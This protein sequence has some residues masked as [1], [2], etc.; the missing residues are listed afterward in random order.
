MVAARRPDADDGSLVVDLAELSADDLPRVGGKAANL[1]ELIRAGFDVPPGFCITTQAYRRAVAGTAVEDGSAQD[2]AAARAAVLAAPIPEAVSDAVRAA[3]ADLEPDGGPVAVRSSATAED[4]PGASFAG[5]QDTYLDVAGIDNVLDAVH[6]CWASLWTDRAVAYRSAQ[7]IDG[8]GVALAVVVQRMVDAAAAGVL[9]TAD[10]VTGRRRQAVLDAAPGLGESVVSGSVDPDHFVVDTASGRILD[11][12]PG[13]SSD[14]R[15][16][17]LTDDQVLMLAALGGRV[18]EAFGSPQ[19]IEWALDAEA[20][21]WVTQSRPITTLYPIPHRGRPL[22]GETRVY[23][24]VSLAQGL[25]RPITPMGIATFRIIGSGFLDLIGR[26]PARI[27]DGPAGFAVAGDRIFV[28]ATPV[29]RSAAGRAI[30][31][32]LLDVMEARSSVVLR[33]LLPDPRFSVLPGTRRGFARGF[34]RLAVRIRLPLIAAQAIISPAAA[35]HRVRRLA[36]EVAARDLP[37][38]GDITSRVDAVVAL[39]AGAMPLAPRSL[40]AA[41]VGFAALSL[42]GRLLRG[43]T[44]PGDLQTVLRSVPDNV[45][46]EMD[47]E[48]WR[49]A[50]RARN[51][52][53]SAAALETRTA[54]DLA[55]EYRGGRLPAVLQAAMRD[56]LS[57][58]GHRAVAEIDLGMP[59]WSDDPSHLFGV[60]SG[61]LRLGA[62]AVTPARRFADGEREAEDM[63]RTL[64]RRA[65]RRGRLRA[66]L[67]AA[68]LR[69]ARALIGIREM[70][71]FLMITAMAKA[72]AEMARIGA[73][74]A[75]SNRI[76]HAED[77]FFLDFDEVKRAAA[78]EDLRGVV[79]ERRERYDTELRRRHVPRVLLSDG[80]ELEALASAAPPG[81][82][83]ALRGTPASAGTVTAS[84]R[85]ILDPAGAELQP[86]EILV[87]PSTDPGW[88][89]LFLTAGGLVMEMGG[90]NSHG[91]VVARE[92][93]IPAV[94]GVPGATQTIS[95]G[96]EVTVDGASGLVTVPSRVEAPAG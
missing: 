9:F 19:D 63:V 88:T 14:D 38:A 76:S 52:A 35:R 66:A 61:Y 80:T 70:P 96:M 23:F 45:T 10:P 64:V 1:G 8:S 77:V 53:E 71:K 4:L 22:P 39:L 93:G 43:S 89:P 36:A 48:L 26:P 82:A 24:C 27:V 31:P 25:H 29:V 78:G 79:R 46:T 56:F 57:R 91:A 74:L 42:A 69:R 87:A 83:G 62:D 75:G 3:Y 81:E 15:P 34:L 72:R 44:K 95:T 16:V 30:F 12:R 20:H 5:Q 73:E 21:A 55:A 33:G 11:R 47:L 32:R 6:R 60:L 37:A 17:S 84:A 90:A 2:A 65:R 94:V 68:C 58:Y 7:G 50:V 40:P 85:V 59:R 67:V 13:G 51:D 49:V 28:D 86:G 92:Y 54:A 41:L 18:E